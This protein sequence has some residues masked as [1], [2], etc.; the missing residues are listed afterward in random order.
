MLR[1][2]TLCLGFCTS[3]SLLACGDDTSAQ[4]GDSGQSATA[5]DAS[6]QGGID[7]GNAPDATPPLDG[8][9][10]GATTGDAAAS[11]SDSSADAALGT[12]DLS[13]EQLTQ[14][15]STALRGALEAS[16]SCT[17]DTD[18]REVWLTTACYDGCSGIVSAAQAQK[19][20]S[21]ISEQNGTS[22]AA[23]KARGCSYIAHPCDPPSGPV[24]IAGECREYRGSLPVA[25]AD[26]GV[27]A[28]PVALNNPASPARADLAA[29]QRLEL[30]LRSVGP[31]A[32]TEPTVSAV[33][34]RFVESFLPRLQNPGGPT[35]VFVFEA[36][37]PGTVQVSIPHSTRPDAFN[38][39]VTIR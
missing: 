26:G 25:R 6:A 3:L 19:L 17:L 30:T 4:K 5:S 37:S 2:E 18:C 24:C 27:G 8:A 29:G 7:G 32:Y 9:P 15:A 14:A 28:S 39:T 34:L 16:S 35:K 13:C 10:P 33:A 22:C 20:E 23:F 31:G 38:L 21:A 1:I 12:S 11:R 36:V